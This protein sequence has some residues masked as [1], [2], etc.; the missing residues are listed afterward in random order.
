[1]LVAQSCPTL[2]IPTDA[3]LLCPW[4]SPGKNTGAGS[5]SLFHGFFLTQG[6]KPHLLHYREILSH[7]RHQ[8]SPT[9]DHGIE[10]SLLIDPQSSPSYRMSSER[11]RTHKQKCLRGVKRGIYLSFLFS[12]HL[13]QKK[14]HKNRHHLG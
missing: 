14:D 11:C 8:E 5:H 2:W 3:R 6:S 4:D 10:F 13:E 9:P 12:T 1:M 7:L